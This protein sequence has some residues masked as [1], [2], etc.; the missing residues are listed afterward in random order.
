MHIK[1]FLKLVE[2]Q[3]KIASVTPFIFGVLY[4]LFRFD[5]LKP[6][7]V[8]YFFIS[9]LCFD[10]F[11][12]SL[13]NYLDFKRAIKKEGYNYEK[14]NAIVRFELKEGT[15][16]ATIVV[17]FILATVFGLMTFLK[18]DY[19]VLVL[20]IIS[21]AVGVLYSAGPIPISRTPFGELFSGF[22]MGLIIPF[23][24][25][26]LSIYD[27]KLIFLILSGPNLVFSFN[28]KQLLPVILSALPAMLCISNIMLANNICDVEDDFTNKRY[29][30]PIHVG[31]KKALIL[32]DLLYIFSYLDIIL[33]V[34]L[35]YLPA[36]SLLTLITSIFV[37]RN[38]RAFHRVQT[39]KD[40]FGFSVMNL[41]LIMFPLILTLAADFVIK[42]LF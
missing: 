2:I 17:L 21:F 39:K 41:V 36:L 23:L 22:F 10:M 6:M 16:I 14:H 42:R 40:T 37:Y 12:T 31:K 7:P 35:G 25:V 15:V 26:Y 1:S 27:K 28:W 13:N 3:T 9:M 24:V 33:C 5:T 18:A 38:L 19:V 11:T 30:L 8:L 20:G 4:T 32:F 34:V 29:T